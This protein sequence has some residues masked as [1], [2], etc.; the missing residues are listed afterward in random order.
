MRTNYQQAI[1][2]GIARHGRQ[3]DPSCLAMQFAEAFNSGA[4]IIVETRYTNGEVYQRRGTVGISGGWRPTFLL[5]HR[6]S[7]HGSSDVLGMTDVQV[8]TVARR[9]S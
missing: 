5:M 6:R 2:R 9:R 3:F 8:G 4:R 1:D 7:D